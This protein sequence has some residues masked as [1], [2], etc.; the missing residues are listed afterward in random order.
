MEIFNF[1]G[2]RGGELVLSSH[3][4]SSPSLAKG[5]TRSGRGSGSLNSETIFA[6]QKF[7]QCGKIP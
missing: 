2:A 1:R 3:G 7:A 5:W 6:L 4:L